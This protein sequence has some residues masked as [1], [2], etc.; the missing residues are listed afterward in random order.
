MK[1]SMYFLLAF[2]LPMIG[3][4]MAARTVVTTSNV[5][6]FLPPP[7]FWDNFTLINTDPMN[8]PTHRQSPLDSAAYAL[9]L[10]MFRV[11]LA[12]PTCTPG[13]VPTSIGTGGNMIIRHCTTPAF[14]P[15]TLRISGN[16][17][18]SGVV[19]SQ[20]GFSFKLNVPG[21][22]DATAAECSTATGQ[23]LGL[24]P[25]TTT[26]GIGLEQ[27]CEGAFDPYILFDASRLVTVSNG[28]L[29]VSNGRFTL[30]NP[31]AVPTD[32]DDAIY[33]MTVGRVGANSARFL[34]N[35]RIDGLLTGP[36]GTGTTLGWSGS[37]VLTAGT[38]GV[39]DY[40]D[41]YSTTVFH[42]AT[43]THFG[44]GL[45]ADGV[46]AMDSLIVNPTRALTPQGGFRSD[47]SITTARMIVAGESV[48]AGTRP[49]LLT[50]TNADIGT[51]NVTGA[52]TLNTLTANTG[53]IN[54]LTSTTGNIATLNSTTANVGTL[55]VTG[56]GLT[57]FAG[58]IS[59]GGAP[60]VVNNFSSPY[61]PS[62]ASFTTIVA[63]VLEK[64]AALSSSPIDAIS[65]EAKPSAGAATS[66]T[67]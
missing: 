57:T 52:S 63:R 31:T 20:R 9:R 50:A 2:L 22:V 29:S 5:D 66:T 11:A 17:F 54:T 65:V 28:S 55:N 47:K 16:V 59:V 19:R 21:G 32:V 30:L 58:G 1:T 24:V 18:A 40:F 37:G 61:S 33:A 39:I 7:N 43:R 8:Q 48:F 12:P 51:L 41:I 26:L 13:A 49:G 42:S 14:A 45:T 27:N 53:T 35:V 25:S 56:T 23:M 60:F 38:I 64:P 15:A 44:T 6:N 62:T 36:S 46:S 4:T 10:A 3:G 34:G 67:V